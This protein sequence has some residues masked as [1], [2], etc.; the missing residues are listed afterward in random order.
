MRG[1]LKAL[2]TSTGTPTPQALHE[3]TQK[4]S[5]IVLFH[6]HPAESNVFRPN[7]ASSNITVRKLAAG[8][9]R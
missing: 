8:F 7:S 2:C 1:M 6:I 5:R 3:R 9:L 4:I